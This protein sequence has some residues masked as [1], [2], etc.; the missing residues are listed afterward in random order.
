MA[1]HTPHPWK[2]VTDGMGRIHI[3]GNGAPDPVTRA[4]YLWVASIAPAGHPNLL[5][6]GRTQAQVEADAAVIVQAPAMLDYLQRLATRIA[7]NHAEIHSGL[8][9]VELRLLLTNAGG[10][11][12]GAG[13]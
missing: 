10:A 11:V 3:A 1:E 7:R 13:R 8:D 6:Q 9:G 5:W 12:P 2:V 4:R